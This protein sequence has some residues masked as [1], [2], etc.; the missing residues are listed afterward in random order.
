[1]STL[2]S[3]EMMDKNTSAYKL[4]N[5]GPLYYLNLDR[6]TQRRQYIGSHL[7]HWGIENPTRVA[8]YDGTHD[9]LGALTTGAYPK[10]MSTGEVACVLSHL[11]AIHQ[12]YH[13]S[14]TPYAIIM[15]D[16]CEL[17]VVSDWP[18]T[19][20]DFIARAPYDWDVIQLA[21]IFVRQIPA[22]IHVR[23]AKDYSTACYAITRH[24]AEKLLHHHVCGQQYRLDNGVRPR[25]V[26]DELI[27]NSGITYSVPLLLYNTELGS[28]IHP[29]H[30]ET[31]HISSYSAIRTFWQQQGANLSVEQITEFHPHPDKTSASSPETALFIQQHT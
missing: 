31:C 2:Q 9:D 29:K 11:K 5:F 3:G 15:E 16:D 24:H 1:M 18:F 20:E 13:S 22:P 27:Y 23:T 12:W 8:A 4:K 19:W 14:T 28:S 10:R 17:D 21:V 6:H 30:L 25:P 26:A 7:A